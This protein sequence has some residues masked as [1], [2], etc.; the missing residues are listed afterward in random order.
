VKRRAFETVQ[1]TNGGVVWNL[2]QMWLFC[3]HVCDVGK[4]FIA[5]DLCVG[6][7]INI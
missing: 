5:I 7:S 1:A 3:F 6:S 4:I 2:V